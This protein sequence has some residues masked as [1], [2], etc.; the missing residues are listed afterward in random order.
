ME[1]QDN[2]RCAKHCLTLDDVGAQWKGA[3]RG[4]YEKTG[5]GYRVEASKNQV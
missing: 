4:G 2:A 5:G 3:N 1:L